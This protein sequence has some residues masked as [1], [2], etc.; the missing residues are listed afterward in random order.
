MADIQSRKADHIAIAASGA[1]NHHQTTLLE[2]VRLEHRSLPECDFSDIDISTKLH[3]FKLS[4]PLMISGMTGGTDE[5][6]EINVA[7]AKAAEANGLAMGLGSQ[8]AMVEDGALQSTF[9][10]K[11]HIP[12]FPLFGNLGVVQAKSYGIEK[13]ENLIKA[14][15]LDGLCI[16]LNPA[17]EMVQIYGDREFKGCLNFIKTISNSLSRPIIIKETGAGMDI[18]TLKQ[19]KSAN[20]STVDISGT[21]GTSWTAV[22]SFRHKNKDDYDDLGREYWNWGCPT[23]VSIVAAAK[24]GFDVI[25][26]GGIRSG[27]DIAKSVSLGAHVAAM[28]QP[29]LKAFKTGGEQE[30][31]NKI[32]ALLRSLQTALLLTG[33]KDLETLRQSS[34]YLGPSLTHELKQRGLSFPQKSES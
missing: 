30:L 27:L 4:A 28:A 6:E 32:R 5:A 2:D 18:G 21:G 31:D 12:N 19:L 13:I 23:A 33:S 26:S 7:L 25:A 9:D 8:R 10:I 34:P 17:Q 11:K 1:A 22:E 14:T 15:S 24:Q 16:H 29:L 3:G 20:I